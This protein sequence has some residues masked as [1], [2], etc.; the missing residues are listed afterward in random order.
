MLN[1]EFSMTDPIRP[2]TFESGRFRRTI[3]PTFPMEHILREFTTVQITVG[4]FHFSFP[5]FQTFGI[6]TFVNVTIGLAVRPTAF[7]LIKFPITVIFRSYFQ[8]RTVAINKSVRLV[9]RKP[10]TTFALPPQ[11]ILLPLPNKQP[12]PN[13]KPLKKVPT[14]RFPSGKISSP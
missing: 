9:Q 1:F 6:F 8:N 4:K 3:V 13:R 2:T 11:T 14:Y 10:R 5:F 12:F 7:K